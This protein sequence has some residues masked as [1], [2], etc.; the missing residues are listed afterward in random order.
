VDVKPYYQDDLVTLY[1]GDCLE[2]TE[3]LTADVLVTDPPYGINYNSGWSESNRAIANDGDVGARDDALRLWGPARPAAVFGTW[4]VS[5]P[6]S[7]SQVLV[8]NKRGVGP[9]MGDLGLAFGT[10]HEDVY[11]IGKWEKRARRRGSV[12]TT[13]SSPS[14]LTMKIGHPTPKPVG[15]MEILIE[16]APPGTIADPFAGS[17]STLVAARNLG[18]K[19][20]GVELEERYC[21]LIAK[22]LDQMCLDFGGAS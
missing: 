7:T 2:I 3:W 18:R 9:G 14:A 4:R 1:H 8:W 12:I 16:C 19:S 20:I 15:L 21:E 10:S 22:R 13:E 5:R 6:D 11:L 17:G